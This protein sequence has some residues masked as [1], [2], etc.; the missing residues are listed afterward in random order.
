MWPNEAVEDPNQF[1]EEGNVSRRQAQNGGD[2]TGSKLVGHIL[3]VLVI[4]RS[5]T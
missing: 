1:S 2:D 5:P 3:D 4:I